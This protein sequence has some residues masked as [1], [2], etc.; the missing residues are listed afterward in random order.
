MPSSDAVTFLRRNVDMLVLGGYS[1]SKWLEAM[2]D[3]SCLYYGFSSDIFEDHQRRAD[4]LLDASVESG[5]TTISMMDGHGRMVFQVFAAIRRRGLDPDDYEIHLYEIDP[6]VHQ[7]HLSFLPEGV[8]ACPENVLEFVDTDGLYGM[9]GQVYLRGLAQLEGVVYFNFCGIS[10]VVNDLKEVLRTLATGNRP[11]FLSWTGRG[12]SNERR[13]PFRIFQESIIR[14]REI[15]VRGMRSGYV[16]HHG[17]GSSVFYTYRFWVE[18]VAV[19][20]L[21]EDVEDVEDVV[22]ERPTKRLKS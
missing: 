14:M 16:S 19:V 1:N 22:K 8:V 4:A 9:P 5:L 12:T 18:P 17:S 3:G 11:C 20:P 15:G 13:T 10:A 2:K 7:W 21:V 6:T